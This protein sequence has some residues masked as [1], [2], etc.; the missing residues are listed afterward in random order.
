MFRYIML[1]GVIGSVLLAGCSDGAPKEELA[2]PALVAQ[3]L[4]A[5]ASHDVFPGE[6]RAR[7][8]PELG[9]RIGGKI[10][11]RFVDVGDRVRKGTVLARL[12][13]ND[14]RLQLDA[15]EA[16]M[17][18]AQADLKLAASELERYRALLERK[19]VSHSQFDAIES[20]FDASQAQLRQAKA[21]LDV[22]RNQADYAALRAPRNGVI[23]Q[24]LAEA[25]QVVAP[26][27]AVF[28]LAADGDREVRI[29]L[30]E[31][32]VGRFQEGMTVGLELWSKP[33]QIFAGRLRELSPAAD[34]RSRTFEARVAFENDDV[35]AE[36]GQSA[37]VLAHQSATSD[38]LVVPLS[39]MTSEN[40][41]AYVWVV[42]PQDMRV[43]KTR[44]ETGPFQSETATV[45]SGLQAGD[46]VVAAGTHLLLE[47][48]KVQ[49][50]D[51]RNLP[52]DMA[53]TAPVVAPVAA[54]D[55]SDDGAAQHA[56]EQVE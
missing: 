24:R 52:V 54:A 27:Q 56:A 30:P 15:A 11:R 55:A 48:Q 50:V 4:P 41:N 39:A 26:G 10:S 53:G 35:G 5:T 40:D 3:A 36:L 13:A 42:N 1:S 38:V 21:N 51:R 28:V 49:P 12:D 18:S 32:D 34:P 45:L 6:V 14:V 43:H 44:V 37:R 33:G 23:A 2:R 9:F 47:A 16:Q 8:E 17:A 25:G 20:R 29:D 46:W 7:Y 22:A 31:Q 19:V